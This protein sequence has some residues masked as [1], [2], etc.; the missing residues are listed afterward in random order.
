MEE[1][2][3]HLL[4][5]S[6]KGTEPRSFR[7]SRLLYTLDLGADSTLDCNIRLQH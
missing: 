5:P 4:N 3:L 7:F 1:Q 2:E 6:H